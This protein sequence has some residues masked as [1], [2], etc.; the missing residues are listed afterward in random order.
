MMHALPMMAH[1]PQ[2]YMAVTGRGQGRPDGMPPMQQSHSA[3]QPS[4]AT[5]YSPA[6]PLPY[7]RPSW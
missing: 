6:Q 7:G 1:G 5:M 3:P 4:H 2:P